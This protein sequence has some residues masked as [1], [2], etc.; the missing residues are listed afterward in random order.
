[1]YT[2][3][4]E[5][6]RIQYNYVNAKWESAI[7]SARLLR[8]ILFCVSKFRKLLLYCIILVLLVYKL[9]KQLYLALCL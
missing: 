9:L 4:T 8:V 7:V 5:T 2:Q 6:V 3:N 1:M